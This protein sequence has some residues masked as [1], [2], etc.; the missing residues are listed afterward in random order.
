MANLRPDSATVDSLKLGW[1]IEPDNQ[2]QPKISQASSV[3]RTFPVLRPFTALMST[4]SRDGVFHLRI[5]V[6]ILKCL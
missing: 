3:R 5:Q 2:K 4:G 1:H 6:S